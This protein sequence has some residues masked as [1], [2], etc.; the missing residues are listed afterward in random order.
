[1]INKYLPGVLKMNGVLLA[2]AALSS[3][4]ADRG[5]TGEETNNRPNIIIITAD[6][7]GWSDLAC[8]GSDLHKTPNLDKLAKQS[9]RF[10]NA[11]AAASICTPTRAS[12]MTG[13][14]PAR[15][16]MTI[17]REWA[18]NQQFDQ[19]LLPPDVEENLPQEEETIAEV[20][21]KAG[22]LT[23]HVG[24]WHIG[25][26][27]NYPEIH[28]FDIKAGCTVWGCPPSYFYP[29]RGNIYDS[30]RY[31]SGLGTDNSGDYF[32]ARDGEYLTDRLTDEALKIMEDAGDTPLFLNMSYYTVHTPIEGKPEHVKKFSSKIKED[33]H[34][35]NAKYAAM[36]YSLDENIGR[37]LKKIDK[38]GQKENTLLIFISDNGGLTLSWDDQVVTNNYPLKSGK[39]SL[40]EGGIRIP[41]M[42]RYPGT[43]EP[44]TVCNQAVST[45][46]IYPTITDI[47]KIPQ[48]EQN[49]K[50][51]GISL[52][53]LLQ[54]PEL[55]LD[56]KF[57]YWHYPHYYL[58][59]TSPVS[60]IRHGDWKLLEY[61]E[62]GHVEL[63]NLEDDPKEEFDLSK[64][65]PGR[66]WELQRELEKWRSDVDAQLPTLNPEFKKQ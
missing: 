45:I 46:D 27:A 64:N 12:L 22:Y 8:Y 58:P 56:R 44:G 29:Y 23:A 34:H 48:S 5:A 65:F 53:S 57:L 4:H 15:L 50:P 30:E 43:T 18:T 21:K 25:D 26:A 13:K 61:F 63:Y 54:N 20:L 10:T 24:K 39:G 33:M 14:Y 49:S 1:M 52:Q 3:C 6:D 66:A 28:G 41:M 17:W 62:D 16:N 31:V 9:L 38:L 35:Q 19:L 36:V 47:L 2:V 37:I 55:Q 51:D 11:Y 60:S 42:I 40:Y 7:L 59:V 32:T